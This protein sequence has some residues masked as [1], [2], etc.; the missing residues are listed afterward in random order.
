[1]RPYEKFKHKIELEKNVLK[2]I[3]MIDYIKMCEIHVLHLQCDCGKQSM[4][5]TH[6]FGLKK[7]TVATRKKSRETRHRQQ[8]QQQK[9]S[10][11]KFVIL[12]Y[13][14]IFFTL[15]ELNELFIGHQRKKPTDKKGDIYTFQN[16]KKLLHIYTHTN[17]SIEKYT[18]NK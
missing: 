2:I 9:I 15:P 17:G 14:R 8:Q 6:L 18:V 7:K 4:R 16:E 3:K 11:H 10:S 12:F 1:M 13:F 5:S